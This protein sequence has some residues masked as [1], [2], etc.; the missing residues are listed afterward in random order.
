M[1]MEAFD[2]TTIKQLH[3]HLCLDFVNSTSNHQNPSDNYLNSYPDLVSWG[4]DVKLLSADEAQRLFGSASQQPERAAAIHH[5][6]VVLRE[7][8]YHILLDVIHDQTHEAADLDTLNGILTEAMSHIRLVVSDGDFGW[9]W[10]REVDDLEYI[11]WRVVWSASELLLS[12]QV[13]R[14]RQCE[15]CDWLFLDVGRGHKRRWCDM[16][17]CGNRAKARRHYL[18][19]RGK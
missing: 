11:I 17:T 18:R 10:D 7:A 8:I 13:K 3:E 16:E 12:D 19:T 1:K 2:F 14:I 15:G 5:K 9:A 6:A 4:L